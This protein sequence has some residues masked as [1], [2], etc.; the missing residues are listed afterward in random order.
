MKTKLALISLA[1]LGG[2][3]AFANSASANPDIRIGLGFR[4]PAPFLPPAPVV[5]VEHNDRDRYEG[6]RYDNNRYDGNRFEGN[7]YDNDRYDHDRGYR[8][9]GFWKEIVV[10]TW[11][12]SCY[13]ESRDWRGRPVRLLEPG[14]FA[15][16]TD[17]VWVSNRG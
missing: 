6:N 8:P 11:V 1:A 13:V 16:R 5:V 3:A 17:R 7:R 14:H 10:K 9:V 12:P 15:F 4:A 2:F